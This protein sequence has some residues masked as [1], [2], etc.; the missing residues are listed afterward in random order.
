[1]VLSH[2]SPV[3]G[4]TLTSS[5]F[6]VII[7]PLFGTLM[8]PICLFL[9]TGYLPPSYTHSQV[10][11]PKSLQT[12]FDPFLRLSNNFEQVNVLAF[13]QLQLVR[14]SIHI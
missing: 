11:F 13:F 2:S 12:I 6:I 10:Q 7:I 14:L 5:L 8:S 3:R 9:T 4:C 1:M